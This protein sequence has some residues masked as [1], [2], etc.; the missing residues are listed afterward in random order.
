[1]SGGGDASLGTTGV[2]PAAEAGVGLT[3]GRIGR[4][5]SASMMTRLMR[6]LLAAQT[7]IWQVM[8][9]TIMSGTGMMLMQPSVVLRRCIRLVMVHMSMGPSFQGQ[10]SPLP[11]HTKNVTEW[12]KLLLIPVMTVITKLIDGRTG[13]FNTMLM[14]QDNLQAVARLSLRAGDGCCGLD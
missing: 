10:S 5:A 12:M 11:R 4:I 9:S 7:E 13:I 14:G 8:S 6:G 3:L 1:M 2:A